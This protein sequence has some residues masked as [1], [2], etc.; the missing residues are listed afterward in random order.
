[1]ILKYKYAIGTH[2]MFYEVEMYQ[3]F[4]DGLVNLLEQVENKHNVYIDICF[5]LSEYLE[6]IDLSK[7]D[8]QTIINK[9]K[10]GIDRLTSIGC[11][12][13]NY[14]Y[15]TNDH[16]IYN[17]ADYRRDF[18]YNYCKKVDLLMWG[19]TDSFFPKQA[20]QVLEGLYE[21]TSQNNLYRYILSFA[22][23][24]MWDESWKVT[25]HVDYENIKFIDDPTQFDNENYAKSF[26]SVDKMNQIN[27]RT[28]ELDIR[29]INYPKIDGSCLVLTSELIKSG[30]N[31]PHSL[32]LYGDDS[33]I[34]TM[35]KLVLG[36]KFVQFTVKNILKVH[37]RRHPKKRL[38]I[39]DENNP[40]G[41]CGKHKGEWSDILDKFSKH[42]LHTLIGCQNKFYTFDD[43]FTKLK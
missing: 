42:N 7:I 25:E 6:R 20:F 18:N 14:Y 37:A 33:S 26:I 1:M 41:F 29:T 19:E 4:I 39:K 43:V 34:G 11:N 2:V 8:K 9:F 35:A 12:N 36:D 16:D 15:K 40:R 3:D 38:Y 27:S 5:N 17:I 24:K 21:H 28:K 23:R 13:I 10:T 22:E 31:L 30:V 32:L